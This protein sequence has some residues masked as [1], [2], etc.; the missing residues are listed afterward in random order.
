MQIQFCTSYGDY[1][2]SKHKNQWLRNGNICGEKKHNT[3]EICGNSSV[4]GYKIHWCSKAQKFLCLKHRSQYNRLGYFLQKTKREPNE[5]EIDNEVAKI[6]FRDSANKA[7]GESLIDTEDVERCK[8]HRWYI[9]EK[10]GNT[11]YVRSVIN[12]KSVSLHRFIINATDEDIVDHVDRDGLNNR[13]QNL[14]TVSISENCVNSKTR[15]KTK[16]KNIYKKGKRYQVQIIRNFKNVYC[17]TFDTI[18]EAVQERDAF[19][20]S[21]NLKYNR[22][23]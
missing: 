20:E 7:I 22:V 16:E 10:Q 15:S 6:I 13:K 17:K 18:D 3:C 8:G 12:G 21:Y 4:D 19:L 9:T 14:R 11:R 5:I 1:L 2:C 23:I